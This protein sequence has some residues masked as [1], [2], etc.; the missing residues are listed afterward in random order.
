MEELISIKTRQVFR[1]YMVGWVLRQ[2]NDEFDAAR[3]DC[4]LKY[5]PP[6]SGERRTL[7]EQYY[8]TS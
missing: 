2:I 4:D 3:I 1:E 8:H 7:V 6:L 5:D